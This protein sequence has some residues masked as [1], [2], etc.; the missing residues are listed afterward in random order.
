LDVKEREKRD[1]E[2]APTREE[3]RQDLARQGQNDG[4]FEELGPDHDAYYTRG[5]GTLLV[6]FENLDHIY[7]LNADRKPWG[8]GYAMSRGWSNLGLMAHDRT[9]YLDEHVH[10]FFERL[11]NEGFFAQFDKVVF[12][13]ASMG[14]YAACAFSA[15]VPGSTVIAIS[16]QATLDRAV[17]SWETRYHKVWRHNSTS[18][19]GYA[20]D[21][22][23]HAGQVYLFFDPTSQLDAMHASLFRGGNIHKFRCRYMG[24]RIASL[25]ANM[26]VLKSVSDACVRGELSQAR[27]SELMRA[28]RGCGRYEREFL[29]RLQ[30]SKKHDLIVR[31]CREILSQCRAPKFRQAPKAALLALDGGQ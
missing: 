25:W 16:P 26:G 22:V 12:Y 9:W 11:R 27:F 30:A 7:E 2:T 31:W 6:T 21:M 24:H 3:W 8:Q 17:A 14:A 20:P 18:R 1:A 28:R 15:A 29:A 23:A 13:G 4:F 19:Y 10:D 5:D